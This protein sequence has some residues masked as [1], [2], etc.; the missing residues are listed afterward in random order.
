MHEITPDFK[1]LEMTK[2]TLLYFFLILAIAACNRNN[3]TGNN[4]VPDQETLMK[5]AWEDSAKYNYATRLQSGISNFVQADI[6]TDPVNAGINQDAA[7]D[8][9]IFRIGGKIYI[10]G[11]NKIG[12]IH[13]YDIDGRQLRY[14]EI[15]LINNVDTRYIINDNDTILIL[16]GSNRT[17]NSLSLIIMGKNNV[18]SPDDEVYHIPSDLKSIYGFCMYSSKESGL[19]YAFANCKSG[20]VQQWLIDFGPEGNPIGK[21]IRKMSVDSQPEGMVADDSTGL[22]YIGEEWAGVH[23][24]NAEPDAGN[25]SEFIEQSSSSNANISY[26]I[27][28]L[29]IYR[30]DTGGGYLVLSSQGNFSYAVFDL[31]T[32]EYLTSFK[33]NDGA[34]VDGVEETDGLDIYDGYV[35][36]QFPEGILVVQDGFNYDGKTKR[37]QNFKII[38]WR[39]IQALI[40]GTE[41]PEYAEGI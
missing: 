2:K 37:T 9:A 38:D 23:I 36:E 17:D 15:G 41:D 29:A 12:G 32:N 8:P 3:Q 33:I 18:F 19:S 35:S 21:E 34:E 28:G 13:L 22:L 14:Y 26:D 30:K 25:E 5:E 39:K 20:Q 11:S 16:G 40:D 24:F 27:E 6:E 1:I 31:E 7:D 4:Q 10:A